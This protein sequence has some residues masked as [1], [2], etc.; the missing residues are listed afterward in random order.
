[1]SIDHVDWDRIRIFYH[2]ALTQ[3]ISH[4]AEQLNIS[5]S[6]LSRT[7][8]NLENEIGK[9]LF[10]RHPRGILLTQ[11]GEVLFSAAKDILARLTHAQQLFDDTK[12]P[13]GLLKVT[14]S[15]SLANLWLMDYV[16]EFLEKYPEMQLSVLGYDYELDLKIREADVAI[17]P[18]IIDATDLIQQHLMTWHMGLYASPEYLKKFGTPQTTDD[19]INHRLLQ[20]TD[21]QV[22]PHPNLNWILTIGMP[23]GEPRTPYLTINSVQGLWRATQAG[24]GIAALSQEYPGLKDLGLVQVLPELKGPELDIYYVYPSYLQHSKRITALG[25]FLVEK[26]QKK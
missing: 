8:Q 18:A 3:N 10:Q 19:L 1:M 20:H 24:L 21:G 4:A 16:P 22:Q 25:D 23:P 9:R 5:Q 15:V 17:R 7:I 13:R 14:T 26:I 11:D 2:V 6:A 12:T